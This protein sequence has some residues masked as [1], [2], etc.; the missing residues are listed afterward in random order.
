MKGRK[1]PVFVGSDMNRE[2]IDFTEPELL[3]AS[4]PAVAI[5]SVCSQLFFFRGDHRSNDLA[6]EASSLF[7]SFFLGWRSSCGIVEI[8]ADTDCSFLAWRKGSDCLVIAH[9]PANL[10]LN[11]GVDFDCGF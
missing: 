9:S 1:E 3:R 10:D 5:D 11:L 8:P 7:V 4:L 6:P 2:G